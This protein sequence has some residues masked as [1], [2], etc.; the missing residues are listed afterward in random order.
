MKRPA[1]RVLLACS[2]VGAASGQ[3]TPEAVVTSPAAAPDDGLGASVALDGDTLAL[4]ARMRA[5]LTSSGPGRVEIYRGAGPGW[6]L[7]AT[8]SP[9][10]ISLTVSARACAPIANAAGSMT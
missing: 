3:L 1:L 9:P 8:L 2:L 10:A 7:E 4:G 5:P 6:A